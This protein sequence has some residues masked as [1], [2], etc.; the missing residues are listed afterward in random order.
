[1]RTYYK[2]IRSHQTLLESYTKPMFDAWFLRYV[3][4]TWKKSL[5]IY[6]YYKIRLNCE[7][8]DEN[9]FVELKMN[10]C[11]K[12]L[13][14]FAGKLRLWSQGNKTGWQIQVL[15]V[16]VVNTILLRIR[17][18]IAIATIVYVYA[19]RKYYYICMVLIGKGEGYST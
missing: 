16:L 10:D 13:D 12:K 1:M 11:F 4:P 6:L 19:I 9:P 5:L 18:C 15:Y 8:S 3:R 2:D 17:S 14:T 7:K